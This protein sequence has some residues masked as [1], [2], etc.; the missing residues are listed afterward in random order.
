MSDFWLHKNEGSVDLLQVKSQTL[1]HGNG[2][3][4]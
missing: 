3:R 4:D 1:L 2:H